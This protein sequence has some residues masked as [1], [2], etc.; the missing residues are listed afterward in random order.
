MDTRLET[1]TKPQL[2]KSIDEL[3]NAPKSNSGLFPRRTELISDLLLVVLDKYGINP[4]E[5]LEKLTE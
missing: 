5:F 4:E 1:G 3:L 2:S